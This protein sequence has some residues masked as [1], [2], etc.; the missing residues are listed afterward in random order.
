M[1]AGAGCLR[2]QLIPQPAGQIREQRSLIA[3][4]QQ[5]EV[6]RAPIATAQDV[7]AV[8]RLLTLV[9]VQWVP[10]VIL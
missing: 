1:V 4:H 7:F 5:A 10:I 2:L 9:L 6:I 3:L 8:T